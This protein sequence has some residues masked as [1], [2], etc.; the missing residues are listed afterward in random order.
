MLKY[1]LDAGIAEAIYTDQPRVWHQ[2]NPWI[3]ALPGN[4]DDKEMY[5]LLKLELPYDPQERNL[6]EYERR[7]C[8]NGLSHIFV[9]ME[10]SAD[11]TRKTIF[12]IR[13]GYVERNPQTTPW[14]RRE[15]QIQ[16]CVLNKDSSFANITSANTNASGFCIVGDSGMGKTSAVNRALRLF[17]QVISHT[18]YKGASF[19]STQIV[20]M[21]LECPHDGSVKALCTSFFMEFDKITGDNTYAKYAQSGRSSTDQMIPQMAYIAQRHGLGL[22]IIDEFQNISVAK[23]GGA[24]RMLNVIRQLMNTIG[25]PILLIGTPPAIEFLTA[26]PATIRRSTGQQGMIRVHPLKRL[27]PDWEGFAKRIWKYQWTDEKTK[28]SPAL[29]D[30]LYELCLGN[31]DLA[32]KLYM[33]TQRLCLDYGLAGHSEMIT[34]ERMQEASER[35]A[36]ILV[37][38]KIIE[39]NKGT[40]AGKSMEIVP[41]SSSI[42]TS[43]PDKQSV[44]AVPISGAKPRK[45]G[46]RKKSAS[47]ED[48]LAKLQE[49][50]ARVSPEDKF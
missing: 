27:S 1:P 26:D 7:E 13:E 25:V 10:S 16:N 44:S 41:V 49:R 22:L 39:Q 46:S 3:E 38:N 14:L 6:P 23:S 34:P 28:L 24:E 42:Y 21:H 20:W 2:N 12:A 29:K 18:Q 30:K 5:N 36:F 4:P 31:I 15:M 32:L 45:N 17:P 35:D 43:L 37:R 9:P 19:A 48:L 33:E 50:G 8:I 40:I 11:I 47:N